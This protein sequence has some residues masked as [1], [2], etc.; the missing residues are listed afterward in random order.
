M[1]ISDNGSKPVCGIS[2]SKY[3]ATSEKYLP[4]ASAKNWS[5]VH[6][7]ILNK[8][9]LIAFFVKRLFKTFLIF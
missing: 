2:A 8:V 6:S 5:S 7:I 1:G 3:H 4:K 9:F